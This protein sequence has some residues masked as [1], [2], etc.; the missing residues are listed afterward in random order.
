MSVVSG[1][2]SAHSPSLI[3]VQ[4]DQSQPH[5]TGN[6]AT[7]A[8]DLA[9]VGQ[10]RPAGHSARHSGDKNVLSEPISRKRDLPK[11]LLQARSLKGIGV[12]K[13]DLD[14]LQNVSFGIE[15][16][17]AKSFLPRLLELKKK[18]DA[19]ESGMQQ[20][21][22]SV[23]K[24][25]NADIAVARGFLNSQ[26]PYFQEKSVQ[27]DKS[28]QRHKKATQTSRAAQQE[29]TNR[30]IQADD[31][32]FSAN[33]GNIRFSRITGLTETMLPV[34]TSQLEAE[35]PGICAWVLVNAG[36]TGV[37]T[38][39]YSELCKKYEQITEANAKQERKDRMERW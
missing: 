31:V 35:M 19:A 1:S 13:K 18:V 28:T 12:I 3:R 24:Q 9:D 29:R 20:Y 5:L 2:Q 10:S 14:S 11:A 23:S 34:S 39:G 8:G 37:L 15:K 36:N 33:L 30:C 4:I 38:A 6:S 17:T 26:I 21:K 16:Q 25:K 27:E 22:G 7:L 32:L